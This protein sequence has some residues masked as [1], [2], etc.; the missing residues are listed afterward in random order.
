[1]GH[2]RALRVALLQ[3]EATDSVTDEGSCAVDAIQV[4]LRDLGHTPIRVVRAG[5]VVK[6]LSAL[7]DAA[8]SLV[9]N[10]C[11]ASQ[12]EAG[13]AARV[14]AT[15]ELAGLAVVG[16]D[17]ASLCLAQ[18]KDRVFAILATARLPVPAWAFTR[19]ELEV[20]EFSAGRGFSLGIVGG[21]PLPLLET[22]PGDL[23]SERIR[24]TAL[25]LAHAQP[26]EEIAGIRTISPAE[27]TPE[28]ERRLTDLGL[29][30][31][32]VI[33]ERGFGWVDLLLDD[34]GRPCILGV[35][36]NPDLSP[37]AGLA[38]LAVA[39]GWS[40]GELLEAIIRDALEHGRQPHPR[41]F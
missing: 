28:L 33:A 26:G 21:E 34:V 29:S 17:S 35:S 13:S 16:S 30:A 4:A 9:F 8:V 41:S 36:P 3:D 23:A 11:A 37:S 39:T 5:G 27:V 38:R 19:P 18:R 25:P 20:R 1:M 14:Q 15:L 7:E 40:Y 6:W 10:L 2:D 12:G 22:V 32:R 31:W 24:V